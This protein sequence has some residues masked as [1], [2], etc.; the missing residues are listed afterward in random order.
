MLLF[1]GYSNNFT[2]L[3]V[4]TG[5]LLPCEQ[6]MISMEQ[7]RHFLPI[8][9]GKTSSRPLPSPE[10]GAL[11]SQNINHSSFINLNVFLLF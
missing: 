8:G 5:L 11:M 9:F 7:I 1:K 3:S 10:F 6:E 4:F 2:L